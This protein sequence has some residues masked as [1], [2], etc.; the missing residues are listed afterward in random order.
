[1][2]IKKRDEGGLVR[3]PWK[4]PGEHSL[5]GVARGM[6]D[7]TLTRGR[8][9]KLAGAALVGSAL[10]LFGAEDADAATLREQRRRCR[11]R[12]GGNGVFCVSDNGKKSRCCNNETTSNRRCQRGRCGG[13]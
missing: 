7:G 5:D 3:P 11:R 13:A 12:H 4:E 8:A 6:A 9:I 10:A 1:M 2:S